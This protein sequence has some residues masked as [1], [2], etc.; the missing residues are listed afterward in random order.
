MGCAFAQGRND[1][2]SRR[3]PRHDRS[4]GSVDP[5]Y[6]ERP[7]RMQRPQTA[8]TA[9]IRG[10]SASRPHRRAGPCAK[11]DVEARSTICRLPTAYRLAAAMPADLAYGRDDT[12]GVLRGYDQT[13]TSSVSGSYPHALRENDRSPRPHRRHACHPEERRPPAG[14]SM[15]STRDPGPTRVAGRAMLRHAPRS[16]GCRQPTGW[17]RRCLLISRAFR[18]QP[19]ACCAATTRRTPRPCPGRTPMPSARTTGARAHTAAMPVIPRSGDLGRDTRWSRRG[20]PA[21]LA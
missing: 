20:I 21:Q 9:S 16:V 8:R 4:L 5:D 13:N 18:R 15:E 2:D 12:P 7:G 1:A 3:A 19:G 11:G 6:R 10:V 17:L 14:H